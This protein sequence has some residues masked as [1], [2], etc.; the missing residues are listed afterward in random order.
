MK[1]TTFI[2]VLNLCFLSACNS[3]ADKPLSPPNALT[4]IEDFNILEIESQKDIFTLTPTI[5]ERL[6]M[7][8]PEGQRSIRSAKRLMQFLLDNGDESLSYQSGATLT[9][10]QAYNDLNANCLSLSILAYSLAEHLGLYGQFQKVHIPEYWALNNGFNLLTGHINLRVKERGKQLTNLRVIYPQERALVID[11]DPNSRQESFKTSY[12]DKARITAMF[13]NNKGA[14]AMLN[15]SY[16]LAYSYFT[17]AIKVDPKYSG[18]WG[19]LGVL[20]RLTNHFKQAEAAYLHAIDLDVNNHTAL[21]NLALIYKLTNREKEGEDILT[22]LDK[23]RQSN[24]YYH[25]SLGND[26][27][28]AARYQDALKHYKKARS[29]NIKLH[30]SDFG[31][32]K[33]YYQLGDLKLARKYLISANNKA[34]FDHDK[35]RYESKLQAIR[36]HTAKLTHY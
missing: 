16:D 31:L 32:A 19:N 18:A 36:S 28:A 20:L 17:G 7:S 22:R 1:T 34:D 6:D 11:F 14:A 10:A 4:Q 13:Y 9:A 2:L 25:I 26:A 8:F 29:L 15:E 30:D 23:K 27:Y 24:P 12:I 3:T 35:K 21:G 5:K 33:T